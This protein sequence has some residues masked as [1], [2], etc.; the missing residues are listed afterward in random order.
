MLCAVTSF[1][2]CLVLRVAF[3][4]GR[5]QLANP[6]TSAA[7]GDSSLVPE[8]ALPEEPE[9][10]RRGKDEVFCEEVLERGCPGERSME[11]G[12]VASSALVGDGSESEKA[13]SWKSVIILG[14]RSTDWDRLLP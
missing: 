4:E 8:S 2:S 14:S 3:G 11:R 5:Q 13:F 7:S 12:K 10:P 9:I 6:A 1:S